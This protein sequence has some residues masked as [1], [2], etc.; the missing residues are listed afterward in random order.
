MEDI[1]VD[2][3]ALANEALGTKLEAVNIWIG[4]ERSVSSVHKDPFENF[5]CV[6]RGAKKIVL[7]PPTDAPYLGEK[8]FRQ[9]TYHQS[10][11]TGPFE[12]RLDDGGGWVPWCEV[13]PLFPDLQKHPEF[14][15]AS[16]V[17]VDLDAGDSIY[18][19]SL[20][21]HRVSHNHEGPSIA[22]NYWYDME[23]SPTYVAYM[24]RRQL[25]GM[26]K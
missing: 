24:L 22:I 8:R 5:Y 23:F 18:I 10:E 15:N 19:P 2:G 26:D 16:P 9:S 3:I 1:D 14:V 7:L 21:Y 4:D 6:V 17:A 12:I 13:D 25:A 20:W 11:G